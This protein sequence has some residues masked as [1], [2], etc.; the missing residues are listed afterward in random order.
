MHCRQ[1]HICQYF[2]Y[3]WGDFVAA[4]IEVEFGM[5]KS[6]MPNVTQIGQGVPQIIQNRSYLCGYVWLYIIVYADHS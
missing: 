4:P 1:L 6:S 3:S 2:G 5:E